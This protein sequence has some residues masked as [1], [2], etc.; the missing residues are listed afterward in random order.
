M[1]YPKLKTVLDERF[2]L[3]AE[4]D[5]WL[6]LGMYITTEPEDIY[7]L[8]LYDSEGLKENISL[9]TG[10]RIRKTIVAW[11][12]SSDHSNPPNIQLA[13]AIDSE[14]LSTLESRNDI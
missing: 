9:Q 11:W 6:T 3:K 14:D 1:N 2:L 5:M 8:K 13:R 12:E 4:K 10:R 7:H